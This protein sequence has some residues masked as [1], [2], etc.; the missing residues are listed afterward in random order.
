MT[1][2]ILYSAIFIGTLITSNLS[3]NAPLETTSLIGIFDIVN[4]PNKSDNGPKYLGVNNGLELRTNKDTFELGETIIITVKNNGRQPLTFPDAA[5][6]LM[7]V[8]VETKESFSFI[9]AQVLT[10]VQPGQSKSIEWDQRGLDG[11]QVKEG[12]YRVSVKTIPDQKLSAISAYSQFQ[13][14]EKK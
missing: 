6:G 12:E 9:A 13:I 11:I 7:I 8:N 4:T 3:S 10:L 1:S 14:K 5:L 2:F